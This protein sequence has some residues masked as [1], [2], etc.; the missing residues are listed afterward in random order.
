MD[1]PPEEPRK[2]LLKE[3]HGNR[4][5]GA[6]QERRGMVTDSEIF[7]GK[8]SFGVGLTPRRQK[9]PPVTGRRDRRTTGAF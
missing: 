4:I 9:V 5:R 3:E 8:L 1:F 2:L 6:L 7:C